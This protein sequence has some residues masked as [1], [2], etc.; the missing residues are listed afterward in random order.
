MMKKMYD[1]VPGNPEE[2]PAPPE[3]CFNCK[4]AGMCSAFF[5]RELREW[6]ATHPEDVIELDPVKSR[7]T[8]EMC[9]AIIDEAAAKRQIAEADRLEDC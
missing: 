3:R 4:C 2:C 7:Q 8:L 9:L 5:E 1:I 6:E